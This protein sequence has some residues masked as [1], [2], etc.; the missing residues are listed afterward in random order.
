M[1]LDGPP[2]RVS[3]SV[4]VVDEPLSHV[5]ALSSA[6]N[7]SASPRTLGGAPSG[8]SATLSFRGVSVPVTAEEAPD[9]LAFLDREEAGQSRAGNTL[10]RVAGCV[11]EAP[12]G[13]WGMRRARCTRRASNTVRATAAIWQRGARA[14][15]RCTGAAAALQAQIATLSRTARL[16]QTETTWRRALTL[17][18]SN[19]A[20][21][22]LIN[23]DLVRTSMDDAG[24]FALCQDLLS[25][26][27]ATR[28]AV[29]RESPLASPALK[30]ASPR[31]EEAADVAPLSLEEPAA[32]APAAAADASSSGERNA[33]EYSALLDRLAGVEAPTTPECE[34]TAGGPVSPLRRWSERVS[35]S[36]KR[37]GD[38]LIDKLERL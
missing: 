23:Q 1:S 18:A 8:E 38:E 9:L 34:A 13:Q 7:L 19:S 37:A 4:E 11:D 10:R 17:F 27:R 25:A 22:R 5:H 36:I 16:T 29:P 14:L 3:L 33:V 21:R 2:A 15:R 12:T 31:G 26:F 35:Q 30:P 28:T 24:D 20:R 32:P 6:S